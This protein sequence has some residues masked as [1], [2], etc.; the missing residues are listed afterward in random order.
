MRPHFFSLRTTDRCKD[1]Q[2]SPWREYTLSMD[3]L[4]LSETQ[5]SCLNVRLSGLTKGEGGHGNC[6]ELFFGWA[7]KRGS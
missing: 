5:Y 1:R 4:T 6:L 7:Q 2:T 3:S